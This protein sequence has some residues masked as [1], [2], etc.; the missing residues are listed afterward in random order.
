MVTA[1]E[2]P[3]M[4]LQSTSDPTKVRSNNNF[5]QT[6]LHP[7]IP[8]STVPFIVSNFTHTIQPPLVLD[9]AIGST[10]SRKPPT[11]VKCILHSHATC[12]ILFLGAIRAL[13]L[14]ELLQSVKK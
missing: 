2:P 8:Y 11:A 10:I 4:E 7:P 5:R 9:F 6:L 12:H 13:F 1:K 14:P 3:K